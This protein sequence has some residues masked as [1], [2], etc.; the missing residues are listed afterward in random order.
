MDK[1]MGVY[2][3]KGCDIGKS[4]DIDKLSEVSTGEMKCPLCR[5]FDVM[6]T[7]D[8]VAQI[9]SDIENEGINRERCFI[10]ELV[11]FLVSSSVHDF[12]IFSIKFCPSLG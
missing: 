4:L 1:K 6:C 12:S 9:R 3:C 5:T 8:T 11:R 2:I 7:Q 10:A